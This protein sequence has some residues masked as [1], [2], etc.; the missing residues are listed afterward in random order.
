MG[1][2]TVRFSDEMFTLNRK[3]YEPLLKGLIECGYGKV[4][5]TWQY[6][7][8]DTVRPQYLDLFREA[9]TKWLGIGIEAANQQIRREITKGKFEDVDI[10]NVV[11]IIQD[12]GIS[13]G[14]NYIFGFEN[15]TY[16]DLQATLDLSMELNTEFANF[17]CCAALPGSPLYYQAKANGWALPTTPEQYSFYSYE[18]LPLPTKHLTATDV[19]RFRDSAFTQYYTRPEYLNMIESKFGLTARQNIEEITKIKLRRKLIEEEDSHL[20]NNVIH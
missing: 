5:R 13:V 11:K 10:R 17:Y 16:D 18:C 2:T 12:H 9:G 3:Y 6:A 19:L 15:E 1:V 7:R 14:G 8:V 20:A 4:I